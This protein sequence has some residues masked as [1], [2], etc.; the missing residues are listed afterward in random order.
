MPAEPV[1]RRKE[2][3]HYSVVL[4]PSG[5]SSHP[6]NFSFG[7]IG[8]VILLISTVV[9]IAGGVIALLVYTPAG[10][11]VPI[12]RTELERRYRMEMTSIQERLNSI[13]GEM[14]VLRA[15]NIKLRKALGENISEKDSS[16]LVERGSDAAALRQSAG[17]RETPSGFMP[18][19]SDARSRGAALSVL[20]HPFDQPEGSSASGVMDELPM[21]LPAEGYI[22]RGFSPGEYHYGLDIAGKE[23]SPVIAAAPGT[24]VFA[25]WTYEFGFMLIIAHGRGYTTVY[26]HNQSLLKSTGTTVK[27]GDLIAL[28]GNTGRSSSGPHLHFELWKDGVVQN[29][30]DYLLNLQ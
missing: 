16:L 12:S 1:R 30:A 21:S 7:R 3:K 6:K 11:L 14:V 18:P 8:A 5:D 28:L 19:E 9:L 26:K 24:I 13:A 4:I 22:S 23:G 29:P 2:K 10:A 25:D 17:G 20:D 27:R 15:Y